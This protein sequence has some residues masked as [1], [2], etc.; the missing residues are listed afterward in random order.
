MLQGLAEK[1]Q[2]KGP[3]TW[4]YRLFANQA[5]SDGLQLTHWVK[6]AKDVT[7]NVRPVA[8]GD[9]PFAKCNKEVCW[10]SN[11]LVHGNIRCWL[12]LKRLL[13]GDCLLAGRNCNLAALQM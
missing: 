11:E 2:K 13:A 1:R 3:V 10:N 9:Y 7:G 8:D 5:R 4:Q 6:C 12:S